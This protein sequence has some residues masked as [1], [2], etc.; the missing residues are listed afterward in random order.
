[1]AEAVGLKITGL[2]VLPR[3]DGEPFVLEANC[4]PG[5]KALMDTTGI[6]I[7]EFIVDYFERLIR[8]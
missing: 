6:K 3:D 5:Y 4:F 1:V 2:D 8:G 7:H